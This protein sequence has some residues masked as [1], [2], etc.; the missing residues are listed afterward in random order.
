MYDAFVA[1][2]VANDLLYRVKPS[3]LHRLATQYFDEC[4][5]RKQSE[6]FLSQP[7]RPFGCQGTEL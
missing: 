7:E 4:C 1:L 6:L 2:S 5:K 3:L